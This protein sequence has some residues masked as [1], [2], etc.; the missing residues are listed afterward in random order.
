LGSLKVKA[1]ENRNIFRGGK[2]E[3]VA[4]GSRAIADE[5]ASPPQSAPTQKIP[6][7]L[8][9]M[10]WKIKK[11]SWQFARAEIFFQGIIL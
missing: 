6:S 8:G 11:K 4:L 5:A 7:S 1:R 9:K 3:R 10:F 2:H